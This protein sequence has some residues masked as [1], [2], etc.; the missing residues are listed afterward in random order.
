MIKKALLS[1][2]G[3]AALSWAITGVAHAQTEQPEE[4]ATASE[5]GLV[6]IIVTATRRDTNL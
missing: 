1:C 5:G 6:D 2:A 3:I 4:A